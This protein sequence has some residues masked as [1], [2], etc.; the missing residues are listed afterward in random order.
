MSTGRQRPGFPPSLGRPVG[1]PPRTDAAD[2][3]HHR[4]PDPDRVLAAQIPADVALARTGEPTPRGR[5]RDAPSLGRRRSDRGLHDARRPPSIRSQGHR[6]SRRGTASRHGPADARGHRHGRS[7]AWAPRPS[8]SSA[9]TGAA[10]R[11]RSRTASTGSEMRT[12]PPTATMADASSRPSS[13]TSIPI[14]S[15]SSDARTAE[16][17]AASLVDDLARRLAASGTSLTE[18]VALFVAARRPFLA[19]LAGLGR[20]RTLDPDA[21]ASCTRTPRACST[22]CCFASSRRTRKSRR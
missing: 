1:A 18:S 12:A 20:R 17:D 6:A 22:G 4:P 8:G 2:P 5:P 3:D 11:R 9:S 14:R 13:P 15:T 19:E 10:T 21:S 16:A 7:P